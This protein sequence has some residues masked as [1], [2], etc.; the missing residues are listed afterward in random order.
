M[1]WKLDGN[2]TIIEGTAPVEEDTPII[3]LPAPPAPI[4]LMPATHTVFVHIL[5]ADA[6]DVT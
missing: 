5:F 4:V 2:A 3:S 1:N 6:S